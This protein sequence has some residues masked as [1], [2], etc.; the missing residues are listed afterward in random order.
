MKDKSIIAHLFGCFIESLKIKRIYYF[1]LLLI[2]SVLYFVIPTVVTLIFVVICWVLIVYFYRLERRTNFLIATI[3]LFLCFEMLIVVQEK[4]AESFAVLWYSFFIVGV[5]QTLIEFK[6]KTRN[7]NII[8]GLTE[9]IKKRQETKTSWKEGITHR[10]T[11]FAVLAVSLVLCFIILIQNSYDYILKDKATLPVVIKVDINSNDK[12][13]IKF[14]RISPRKKIVPLPEFRN[15]LW[16]S[17]EYGYIRTIVFTT[18][19]LKNI[20]GLEISIGQNTVKYFHSD[21]SAKWKLKNGMYEMPDDFPKKELIGFGKFINYV[22]NV[23]VA[24]ISFKKSVG[25]L[26]IIICINYIMS[27]LLIVIVGADR[28]RSFPAVT[29]VRRKK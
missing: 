12:N 29:F 9:N 19:N 22:G 24:L 20:N 28:K 14:Y 16:F 8:Y 10:L 18:N 15:K 3:M 1:V 26:S 17:S 7:V 23:N 25:S 5:V 27:I 11:V 6:Y 4:L 21:L 2:F 13:Y